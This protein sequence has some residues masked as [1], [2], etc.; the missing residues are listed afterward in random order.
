MKQAPE[1][2]GLWALIAAAWAIAAVTALATCSSD[3][4]GEA[5]DRPSPKAPSKSSDE[6]AAKGLALRKAAARARAQS[7]KLIEESKALLEQFKRAED[8]HAA[9][10]NTGAA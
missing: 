4:E 3:S 1:S 6:A 5:P 10:W 2:R 8:N 9:A 7:A